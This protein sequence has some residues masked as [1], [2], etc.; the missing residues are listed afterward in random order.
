MVNET[1]AAGLLTH[2]HRE[3]ERDT[4]I[5]ISADVMIKVGPLAEGPVALYGELKD[6]VLVVLGPDLRRSTLAA[7]RPRG[8]MGPPAPHVVAGDLSAIEF[9]TARA[10]GKLYITGQIT[11]GSTTR[12]FLVRNPISEVIGGDI[13]DGTVTLRGVLIGETF[14]VLGFDATTTQA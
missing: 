4:P 5:R 8:E 11:V 10:T 3:R 7:A 14:E 6:G 13:T 2:T 1:M 9:R 12:A